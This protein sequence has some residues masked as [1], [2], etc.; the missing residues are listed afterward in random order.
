MLTKLRVYTL[1]TCAFLL[2]VDH[3]YAELSELG[4]TVAYDTCGGDVEC[5][6]KMQQ[7]LEE[8]CANA[9][10]NVIE[11]PSTIP[12]YKGILAMCDC[13]RKSDNAKVIKDSPF[14]ETNMNPNLTISNSSEYDQSSIFENSSKQDNDMLTDY[15]DKKKLNDEN[16]IDSYNSLG[17]RASDV[18]KSLSDYL[19]GV[20]DIN[21]SQNKISD[22]YNSKIGKT[23][24]SLSK[25]IDRDEIKHSISSIINSINESEKNQSKQRNARDASLSALSKSVI[26]TNI[27][28]VELM[29][30]RSPDGIVTGITDIAIN[31]SEVPMNYNDVRKHNQKIV[32]ITNDNYQDR[33]SKTEILIKLKNDYKKKYNED[34]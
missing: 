30:E 20:K 32:N 3:S 8:R 24:L 14:P 7:R 2:C 26:S 17:G 11:D 1:C 27:G 9:R 31:A 23:Q 10:K 29:F 4:K 15:F 12:Y 28:V 25:I 6:Q 5:I 16:L 33:R 13:S 19:E 18:N 22:N 34:Y 21:E